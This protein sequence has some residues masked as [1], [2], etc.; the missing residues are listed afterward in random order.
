MS[1]QPQHRRLTPEEYLKVE[2]AA[3]FK[4]EY[5]DGIMYAMSGAS[6]WHSLVN[7][8]L[9]A[10]FWNALKNKAC[11]VY[12]SD[13]RI[14]IHAKGLYTYP[15]LSIVCGEARFIDGERD[16]LVNPTVLIEILSQ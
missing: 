3:E 12:T 13:L 10:A 1:A 9:I 2:R 6:R 5:F 15:D 8:N 14:R 7:A 11:S 4:S 16:T